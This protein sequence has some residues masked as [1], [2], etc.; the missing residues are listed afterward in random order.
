VFEVSGQPHAADIA[1]G[2]IPAERSVGYLWPAGHS[3]EYHRR[4][5]V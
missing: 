4:N 5:R 3:P 2:G 1:A